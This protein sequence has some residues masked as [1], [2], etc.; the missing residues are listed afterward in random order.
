MAFN[1]GEMSA[2]VVGVIKDFHDLSFHDDINALCVTTYTDQYQSY[3]VKINLENTA[4]VL[5]AL[6]TTWASIYPEM[7]YEYQFLDEH[8][9]EFY[10]TEATMLKMIRV[11]SIIAIFIAC[12]GLYGL[13]AFMVAQKTKEI[14][15][16]KV[17]GSGITEILWIFGK[18]FVRLIL[19]SFLIAA[20]IGWWLMN[21]WL[22]DFE[23][24]I[25]IGPWIFAAA[26]LLILV[27]AAI[28]VG[29]QSVRAALMNPV[30][31]LRSE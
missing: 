4:R 10:E 23:Y 14:G 25:P 20:P 5:S 26:A 17:L 22:Q 9:A 30:K 12:L 28:T 19:V 15:I 31:S 13:V 29:Y 24:H 1:G 18:E 11:F 7:I 27:V 2:T 16:R 6:E 8:I 3:A 21:S